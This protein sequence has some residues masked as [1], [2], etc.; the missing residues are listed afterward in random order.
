[1]PCQYYMAAARN[2]LGPLVCSECRFNADD[3]SLLPMTQACLLFSC[4]RFMRACSHMHAANVHAYACVQPTGGHEPATA[5][6]LVHKG[7]G[8]FWT[9]IRALEPS[10]RAYELWNQSNARG[11]YSQ[12]EPY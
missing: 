11:C 3:S 9:C 2:R 6:L 10:R 1:M 5:A 4:T 8:T 12:P 7:F